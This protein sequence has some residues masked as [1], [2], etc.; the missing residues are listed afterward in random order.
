MYRI[1]EF[2]NLGRVTVKTFRWYDELGFLVPVHT[3]RWT[4]YR[5]Y[6]FEQLAQLHRI[7]MF[8]DL[9][10]TLGQIRDLLQDDVPVEQLRGML[11]LK[12][13]EIEQDV[14]ERQTSL[15]QIRERLSIIEQEE[16]MPEWKIGIET[17]ASER[18]ASIH[19]SMPTVPAM[20]QLSMELSKAMQDNHVH[21]RPPFYHVYRHKEFRTEDMDVQIAC[22]L[23][24]PSTLPQGLNI[25]NGVPV[26]VD[27]LPGVE[28]MASLT[29]TGDYNNIYPAWS[30]LGSWVH[31]HGYRISG[32][33]REVY[34]R[35]SGETQ[36]SN[37][38]L[39]YIQFPVEQ[40]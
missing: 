21:T 15:R 33:D 19:T 17:V 7:L 30:A 5:Y 3:D 20:I 35:S 25:G 2:S 4:N 10:L 12:Q 8:K 36:D 40:A 22:T 18:V 38:Y 29:Y 9:G 16:D 14:Q 39:T 31:N 32:P 1:G 24:D 11:L 28:T 34:V 6:S 13:A 27:E 37:D 26:V 23:V